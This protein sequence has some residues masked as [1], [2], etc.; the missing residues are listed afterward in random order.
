[1]ESP[2]Q[3]RSAGLSFIIQGTEAVVNN[4]LNVPITVGLPET[5]PTMFVSFEGGR[6]RY[7]SSSNNYDLDSI[8]GLVG[9]NC[10]SNLSNGVLTMGGFVDFGLGSFDTMGILGGRKIEGEGDLKRI[11]GG[12]MARFEF[13]TPKLNNFYLDSSLRFGQLKQDYSSQDIRNSQN[14][15]KFE[16][17][18]AY[19]GAH[20]G[21]GRNFK[22]FETSMLDLYGR[23]SYNYLRGDQA[24]VDGTAPVDFRAA[25]S[26]VARVGARLT[27]NV[28]PHLN[29]QFG[30][31]FEEEFGGKTKA[32][33]CGYEIN[34]V[35]VSGGTA[36]A[37][38]GIGYKKGGK[39]PI[40][41]NFGIDGYVGRRKGL[42]GTLNFVI[43]F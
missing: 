29:L 24:M 14:E 20:I 42:A 39:T 1:M 22:I 8:M 41:F 28:S 26:Q 12:V 15:A 32:S 11:G 19:F 43:S 38:L 37:E 17:T 33:T 6:S 3:G 16:T 18:S 27:K 23:F 9:L 36:V 5:C 13:D 35:D 2:L 7:G 34:E 4:A 30:L 21:L 25:S 40:S 31:G 10:S